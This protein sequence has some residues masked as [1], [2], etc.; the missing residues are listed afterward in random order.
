MLEWRGLFFCGFEE[1]EIEWRDFPAAVCKRFVGEVRD[2]FRAVGK[3]CRFYAVGDVAEVFD[4]FVLKIRHFGVIG[5]G[6]GKARR[7]FFDCIARRIDYG[8]PRDCG[9]GDAPAGVFGL[10]GQEHI[11]HCF[12]ERVAYDYAVVD[13]FPQVAIARNKRAARPPSV[14]AGSVEGEVER[15]SDVVEAA[16]GALSA[17]DFSGAFLE[18][19]ERL[20]ALGAGLR[21]AGVAAT[22]GADCGVYVEVEKSRDADLAQAGIMVFD[23]A[24]E[25]A[26][27]TG[28]EC[29]SARPD[30]FCLRGA[31]GVFADVFFVPA[32]GDCVGVGIV[33][34]A[35]HLVAD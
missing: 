27:I 12:G 6:A 31:V 4:K 22:A 2:D 7:V 29:E 9:A 15:G 14:E 20:R 17:E 16:L 18:F 35:G 10:V 1:E 8:P 24:F 30:V 23:E 3:G 34:V 5:C 28:L 33:E 11:A 19:I 13:N 25:D 32:I 21:V 26:F